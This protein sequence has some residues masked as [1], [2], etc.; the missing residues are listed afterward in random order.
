M[1]GSKPMSHEVFHSS[2]LSDNVSPCHIFFYSNR[3]LR[4]S[5]FTPKNGH[6][7][8]TSPNWIFKTIFQTFMFR[9]STVS[10]QGSADENLITSDTTS[11]PTFGIVDKQTVVPLKTTEIWQLDSQ[12]DAMFEAEDTCYK[13]SF[14]IPMQ[15]FQ[16][17]N[18]IEFNYFCS[19]RLF[20]E[21]IS[22]S[23]QDNGLPT[24]PACT[25]PAGF[26]GNMCIV[27]TSLTWCYGTWKKH[28]L[29]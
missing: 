15:K 21:P 17:V 22:Q 26:R 3:Q 27:M 19:S 11:P 14:W 13:A 18:P 9:G 23:V 6:G 1:V 29:L 8:W 28:G 16:V 20:S 10:F 7:S 5:F 4:N 24:T 25:V 12:N 2:T